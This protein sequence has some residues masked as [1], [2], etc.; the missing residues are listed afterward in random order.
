MVGGRAVMDAAGKVRDVFMK[1]AADTLGA[2]PFDVRLE[3]HKYKTDSGEMDYF[4]VVKAAYLRREPVAAQGWYR[5]EGTTYNG[6]TGQ[7]DPYSVYTFSANACEVEVDTET[8]EVEVRKFAAAHDIGKA[9]HPASAQGQIQGGVV[10]GIG[11]ALYENLCLDNGVV[12]NPTFTGYT[13]PTALDTCDVIPIIIES[14]HKDGPFGAKGLGEPPIVG[15]APAILN[16]IYDAIGIRF[17]DLPCLPE[18]IIKKLDKE[19]KE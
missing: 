6:N 8:G 14:P 12:L 2:R 13:V 10:Q 3:G 4:D 7:G 9:I 5:I 18:D 15:V 17:H 1:V 19:I 11:Y 16:A